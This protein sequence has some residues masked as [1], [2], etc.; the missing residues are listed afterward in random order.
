MSSFDFYVRHDSFISRILVLLLFVTI[1][2]A[3]DGDNNSN[4][5]KG[6]LEPGTDYSA[7]IERTEYGTAHITADDW[8][9]LGFG[10]G[11][12]FAQD[13][14]CV[15]ADQ[16]LKV[17]SQRAR[18]F[19]PG[20]D[21][22]HVYSDFAYLALGVIEKAESSL[23]Q[24]SG[25]GREMLKGYVAGFNHFLVETGVD[26]LPGE[27]AGSDWVSELDEVSLMAYYLDVAMLAG[28]RNFLEAIADA[29]P[30]SAQVQAS[31]PD[32]G[33]RK[34]FGGA[35][36][37]IALGGDM[38]VNGRGLLLSNTHLPWEGEL[39]YHEVHLTLPGELDVAGVTLSG[40]MGT[41]I[42]FNDSMAW[43]HTTSPSNQFVIYTLDLVPDNPT[44]YYFGEE[45]RDMLSNTYS[46]DVLQ[47]DGTLL[48]TSRTL[49]S[50]HYGPM[51]NPSAFGLSWSGSTA[52]S[53]F[54]INASNSTLTDTFRNMAQ[55]KSVDE[56]RKVFETVG[57]VPWNHTMATDSDGE[58]LYA[59]TTL[60]PNFSDAGEAAF[61]AL[62]TSEGFN[63]T[64]LAF[65]AGVVVVDGSDPLFSIE[66]DPAATLAGAIPFNEAP[67][68]LEHRDF[69]AN[70]N[71]SYWLSNPEVPLTG[72]SLRYG[73]VEAPRTL[74]TRMGLTQLMESDKLTRTSLE[75]L[76]FANRSYTAEIWRDDFVSYCSGYE[77]AVSSDGRTIDIR[78]ACSL[79]ANWDGRYNLNSI[80]AVFFR[81]VTAR[82]DPQGRL[83][84]ADVFEVAFDANDP[85]ATPR[86]L[87]EEGKAQLLVD[88]ADAVIRLEDVGIQLDSPLG[89]N[90]F[91]LQGD[92]RFALHGGQ[93]G[94]EGAFNIV[95]YS[96]GGA[97]NSSLLDR[98]P[99]S[100]VIN[101]ITRL[102][103]EGY[104]VNFGASFIMAVEFTEEGPVADAILT[105]SQSDD[106]DSPHFS[107]QMSL[108]SSKTWR[109]LAFTREQ[110]E[111]DPMLT[112]TTVTN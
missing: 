110:I 92:Q 23:S 98:T 109:P 50:S 49:Y 112:S 66:E 40:V 42:G 14:F 62:L 108:Y 75:Q 97:L 67:K 12:A 70:S 86:G 2:A 35:S 21:N 91:G 11:Y 22:E 13:R 57:G 33:K 32:F 52:Y 54:D 103:T 53:L 20:E 15:L 106:P 5:E 82:V 28:S 65:G 34:E 9:S 45:E 41:L 102:T 47:D 64:K 39:R 85:V 4:N 72:Y 55:A 3:C 44:R 26:G 31:S 93:G 16:I 73:D 80:G 71:D 81:E 95:S 111:S 38:T 84:G 96:S 56:L 17:R 83:G 100:E 60:V 36:N 68:L 7:I 78:E 58:V 59:D 19:G 79:L 99:R 61:N 25:E 29:A 18:Y 89:D 76:L 1:L 63:F 69:V 77:Q 10:Q 87:T 6:E 43:T 46:I 88:L 30:P 94:R 8:G 74:R 105:Y 51:L 37:G 101:P 104:L 27:C 107:D 48:E 90:Q 24:L